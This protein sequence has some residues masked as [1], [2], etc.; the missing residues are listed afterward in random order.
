MH[1]TKAHEQQTQEHV[2]EIWADNIVEEV[3]VY[4]HKRVPD[5]GN[6]YLDGKT[7]QI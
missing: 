5:D 3:H 4:D 7:C 1:S 2:I 6:R